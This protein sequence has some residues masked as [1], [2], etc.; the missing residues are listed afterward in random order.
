MSDYTGG[1]IVIDSRS[2]GATARI[3]RL[4][5]DGVVDTDGIPIPSDAIVSA[6]TLGPDITQPTP[7]PLLAVNA[8]GFT[9]A[10]DPAGTPLQVAP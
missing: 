1:K 7:I 8:S 6:A 4:R 2:D 5:A 3:G 10:V 9:L